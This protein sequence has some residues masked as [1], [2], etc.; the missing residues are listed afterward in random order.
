MELAGKE[1]LEAVMAFLTT[2]QRYAP[3]AIFGVMV[4]EGILFT[5]FIF[6]GSLITL[7]AGALIQNGTLPYG[8]VFVAIF[9]GF[10]CGDTLNYM[11]GRTFEDRMRAMNFV[12]RHQ[13][14][15]NKAE[16]FL[17]KWDG[18]AIFLS[19]FM[20][21]TRPFVTILAGAFRMRP[22]VFHGATVISTLLLTA[23]LLNAG[24]FGLQMLKGL[25]L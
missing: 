1:M 22:A 7:A 23:G 24:A 6:S 2:H 16:A 3:L 11:I 19:R 15:L 12:L 14:K 4:L 10:W 5:T 25:K 18:S 13:D 20:G 9:T 8:P 21:P 17:N